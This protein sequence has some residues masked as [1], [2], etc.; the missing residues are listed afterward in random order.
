MVAFPT[1]ALSA[2][3]CRAFN[4][5]PYVSVRLSEMLQNK[6][7]DCY[8]PGRKRRGMKDTPAIIS[9]TQYFRLQSTGAA[10]PAIIGPVA[11]PTLRT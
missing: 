2:R 1:Q 4:T 11:G 7:E 3:T 6:W 10:K 5:G 9:A 8:I